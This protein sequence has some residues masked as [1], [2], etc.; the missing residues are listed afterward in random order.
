MTFRKQVVSGLAWSATAN[1]GQKLISFLTFVILSRILSPEAF[2]LVALSTVFI[3]FAET[4][5]DYGFTDAIVQREVLD[6]PHLDTAFWLSILT[7]GLLTVAGIALSPVVAAFF[8]EPRL[9]LILAWLSVGFILSAFS[10]T[11][12]AILRRHLDFRSLAMRSFAAIIVSGIVG[13]SLALSGAG[14]WSLVAQDLVYRLVGAIVLWRA[15]DWRPGFRISGTHFRHL[16]S[17]GIYVVGSRI[18]NFVNR[19][20]DDLLIGYF[21]GP[22]MLGYYTIAYRL[23]LVMINLL[24]GVSTAVAFPAFSR[25]HGKPERLRRAFYTATKLTC[26]ASFPA[27]LGVA[28]LAPLLIPVLFGPGWEPS[29][30]VMQ[31]LALSGILLSVQYF[32]GSVIQAEGKPSWQ[33]GITLVSAVLNAAAFLL[34]VRWGIVAVAAAYVTV[35][36][37][38]SPASLLAVRRLIQI[39]LKSYFG[40]YVA[41]LFASLVMVAAIL[42]LQQVVPGDLR[43]VLQLALYI[44]AGSVVYALIVQL[45]DRTISRQILTFI[46]VLLPD[47]R[48][49]PGQSQ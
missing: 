48:S 6:P 41:P 45:L 27:F 31:I 47:R 5:L 1:W 16:F 44:L 23:L 21:L 10:S 19:R 34:V 7:G 13:V 37:L 22:T 32:N 43:R 3:A 12:R 8:S 49:A 2:G 9:A 4:F 29:I 24:T 25:L 14:V 20:S 46:R 38:V 15:S 40:Q 26:V 42:G 17:F 33:L 36:Y 18:L 28:V 39:D 11:Q 35:G 30:P